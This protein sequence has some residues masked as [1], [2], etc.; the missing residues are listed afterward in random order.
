M[1]NPFE[2]L[3]KH[4]SIVDILDNIDAGIVIYDARGNFVFMNTM[5][6]Y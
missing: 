3:Q 6:A 4:L 2:E 1:F 5:M